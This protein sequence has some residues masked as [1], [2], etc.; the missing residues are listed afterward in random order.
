MPAS[1]CC[2]RS[3]CVANGP[4]T[5]PTCAL[6]TLENGHSEGSDHGRKDARIEGIVKVRGRSWCK[7]R[8]FECLTR[9][10]YRHIGDVPESLILQFSPPTDSLVEK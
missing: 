1:S 7:V 6:R 10:C 9:H 5:S 4:S 2:W 3:G 8:V